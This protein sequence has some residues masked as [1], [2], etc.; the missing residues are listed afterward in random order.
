MVPGLDET[1]AELGL[2]EQRPND[3]VVI[4]SDKVEQETSERQVA[5]VEVSTAAS[6]PIGVAIS[7]NED[8]AQEDA[9]SKTVSG[10]ASTTDP[11]LVAHGAVERMRE[12]A[13]KD[14]SQDSPWGNMAAYLAKKAT[15]KLFG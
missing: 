12:N 4:L 15:E 11:T 13:A 1:L 10:K 14:E 7:T 9:T 2:F 8:K 3:S 5:S 6:A